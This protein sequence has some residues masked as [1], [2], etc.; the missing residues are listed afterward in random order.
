MDHRHVSYVTKLKKQLLT[1][2][3]PRGK[4]DLGHALRERRRK[5]KGTFGPILY[6]VERRRKD[7]EKIGLIL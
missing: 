6:V 7:K 5:D 2:E 1:R 3:V 4:W